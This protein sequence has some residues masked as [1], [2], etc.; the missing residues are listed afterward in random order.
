MGGIF[1]SLLEIYNWKLEIHS[2]NPCD[3][4]WSVMEVKSRKLSS[5]QKS[6]TRRFGCLM[7]KSFNLVLYRC[8]WTSTTQRR[9]STRC[10]YSESLANQRWAAQIYILGPILSHCSAVLIWWMVLIFTAPFTQLCEAA[11]HKMSKEFWCPKNDLW[12]A[13]GTVPVLKKW[14]LWK[15]RKPF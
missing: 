15:V 13:S 6:K 14:N 7:T 10:L 5:W 4:F 3:R 11:R 2:L 9:R 1:N 12:G 8:L